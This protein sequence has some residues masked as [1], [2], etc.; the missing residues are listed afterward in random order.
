MITLSIGPRLAVLLTGGSSEDFGVG[1]M[2]CTLT[3]G[4]LS[5]SD[6]ELRRRIGFVMSAIPLQ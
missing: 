4:A 6:T 3:Q 5:K 1:V 2:V